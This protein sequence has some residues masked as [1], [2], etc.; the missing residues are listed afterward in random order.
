VV[1]IEAYVYIKELGIS[2][3]RALVGS[4]ISNSV[5]TLL[6]YPLSAI[7]WI[8]SGF[9][10]L[11]PLS[12]KSSTFWESHP[13]LGFMVGSSIAYGDKTIEIAYGL[14][15]GLIPALLLSAWSERLV[16]QWYLKMTKHQ[17]NRHVWKAQL[18]SYAFLVVLT[19]SL[20]LTVGPEFGANV[21]FQ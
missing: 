1:L 13:V 8:F 21:F 6:G 18:F 10:M 4:L 15:A 2:K 12:D 17:L 5:S 9:A 11:K 16:L 7:I 3:K 19:V 14:A 20:I